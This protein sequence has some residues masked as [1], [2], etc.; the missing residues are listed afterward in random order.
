[1]KEGMKI[2]TLKGKNII[3]V[4]EDELG[5]PVTA[6]RNVTIPPRMGGVFHVDINATFDTNQVL[7]LHTPYFKEMLTVY[8]HEIVIPPTHNENKKFMQVM[9]IRN[10]GTERSWHLRKLNIVAFTPP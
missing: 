4:K 5:F 8:P 10:V 2:L 3:E 7:T 1:M 6:Q 9:H